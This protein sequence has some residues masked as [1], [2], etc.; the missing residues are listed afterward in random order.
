MRF[1]DRTEL[2][3]PQVGK[4]RHFGTGWSADLGERLGRGLVGLGPF[5]RGSSLFAALSGA[6]VVRC[7]NKGA[8]RVRSLNSPTISATCP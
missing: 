2:P 6:V 4:L 7:G 5:H 1:R 3:G 8:L